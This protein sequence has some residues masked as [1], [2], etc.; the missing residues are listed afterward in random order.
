MIVIESGFTGAF[1]PLDH[2]RIGANPVSGSA[3][4]S[5]SAVGFDAAFAANS[6]TTQ[7]WKPTA[8]SSTWGLTFATSQI[9]YFGIAAHNLGSVGATVLFQTWNGTAWV[10]RATHIPTDD[11]PIFFLLTPLMT[12]RVQLFFLNAIPTIGIISVGDVTEFPQKAMYTGSAAFNRT[13]QD[14]FS[15]TISDGGQALDRFV[16]RRP[17]SVKMTVDH[18]SEA[19]VDAALQP[20]IDYMR[21][22]PVFI[23]DRPSMFP[24]SVAYAYT[25]TPIIPERKIPNANVAM[26]VNFELVGNV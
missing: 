18:L 16:T 25:M 22:K 10:T 20:I 11:S 23:A 21:L 12:D 9:S 15:T 6:Q 24:K 4:A 13:T 8:V 5:T 2:P 7:Y 1:Y 3:T 19:W 17:V 26:G 14:V